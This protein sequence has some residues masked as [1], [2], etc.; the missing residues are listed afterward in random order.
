MLKKLTRLSVKVEG[1]YATEDELQFVN[2]YLSS[3]DSRMS[4]YEKIRDAEPEIVDTT[5]SKM[6]AKDENIF[7]K[8]SMNIDAICIRDMKIILKAMTTAILIDDLERLKDG[9]LLW[10]LTIM[11]AMNVR[12]ISNLVYQTMLA[13]VKD[14]LSSEEEKFV[15]PALQV[16]QTLITN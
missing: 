9:L 6:R 4:F 8:D 14:Y 11:R 7:S 16:S 3:V 10:H 13:I 12:N 1:R 2:D 15:A 5:I